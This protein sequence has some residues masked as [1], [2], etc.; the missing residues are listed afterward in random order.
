MLKERLTYH[1]GQW[2]PES[3][4]GIHIYDSQFMFGDAVFEMARTFNHKFFLLEEHVDRLFRSMDFL[5]I[6]IT[7]TKKEV[8]NLCEKAF[9]IN[10]DHFV[11]DE[12]YLDECRIMII[13]SRCPLAIY[14]EV[15]ELKKGQSW[16]EPTWIIN[17]WPLS[18]TGKALGHFY[19]TGVNAVIPQ[20][21]QIPA[22]FLENKVKNRSR[23]HYQVANLQV[24]SYNMGRD[25]MPL[26]LDDD[27]FVTESTGANFVMIKDGNLVV[28]ELRNMLRGSSMMY[29]LEVIA[30][31]LGLEVITKNF[32]VYDVMN[33]D[34]A[35]HGSNN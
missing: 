22:K 30:P 33:C 12:K 35:S 34:E 3:Q 27:G 4:A 16:N 18:K 1:T 2:I 21:P 31:Q 32:D 23:M 25:T 28:P 7:K 29:I 26:L 17:V 14:R 5:K 20:Q 11:G 9:D 6:P 19:D 24:A 13:V 10:K 15:F 8:I